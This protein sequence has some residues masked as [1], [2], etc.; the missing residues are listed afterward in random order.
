MKISL[1]LSVFCFAI[2]QAQQTVT[3]LGTYSETQQLQSKAV[4]VHFI[5][6][7]GKCNQFRG[8][9]PIDDQVIFFKQE[10]EKRVANFRF[11]DEKQQLLMNCEV[12]NVKHNSVYLLLPTELE[13]SKVRLICENLDFQFGCQKDLYE[14]RQLE[15]EDERA[16]QAYFDAFRRAEVLAK[17][18]GFQKISLLNIDDDTT[19]ANSIFDT[20]ANLGND[21]SDAKDS[22]Q[23]TLQFLEAILSG[24]SLGQ[25]GAS[26]YTLLVTFAME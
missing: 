7:I 6:D 26:T 18:E 4:V 11:M 8:T 2:L 3:V 13:V 16:I 10:L 14:Q 17:S 15:D 5:D 24:S 9:L 21:D 19:F 12:P 20:F 25:G 1:F 23:E 22:M